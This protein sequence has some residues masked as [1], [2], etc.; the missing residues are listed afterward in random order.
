MWRFRE[1]CEEFSLHGHS[2]SV[3]SIAF[4]P[5]GQLLA[6]GSADNHVK[7][8]NLNAKRELLSLMEH[9]SAVTAVAFILMVHFWL[10]APA[11]QA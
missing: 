8:C 6:S 1:K 9:S 2:D 5:D 7:I 4:S 3:C 11:I 10:A